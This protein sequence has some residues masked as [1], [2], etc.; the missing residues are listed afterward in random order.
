MLVCA[1]INAALYA[2]TGSWVQLAL[3]VMLGVVGVLYL[4]MPFLVV[5]DRQIQAKN[6]MGITLRRFPFE[7]LADLE[8]SP[9]AVVITSPRGGRQRLKVSRW[10]VSG[11]DMRRLADAVDAARAA[12]AANT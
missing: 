3:G 2:M 12:R 7:D 9:G 8:V 11:A 5:G 10:L 4:T 6:L 1:A